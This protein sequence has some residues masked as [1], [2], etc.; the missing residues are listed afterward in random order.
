MGMHSAMGLWGG[1]RGSRRI[2]RRARQAAEIAVVD[3]VRIHYPRRYMAD[4]RPAP[5]VSIARGRRRR[6]T[7]RA[8]VIAERLRRRLW[9]AFASVDYSAA[10]DILGMGCKAALGAIICLEGR[11]K[12]S[13]SAIRTGLR[14][15]IAAAL[16]VAVGM[17]C[18]IKPWER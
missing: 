11:M 7:R 3:A 5:V 17:G 8:R 16:L 15:I 12:R 14:A 9:L 2:A 18:D 13:E 4:E 1:V 6:H 10:G